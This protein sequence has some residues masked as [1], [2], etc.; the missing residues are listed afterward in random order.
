MSIVPFT[1]RAEG[2]ISNPPLR[3]L[4]LATAATSLGK[5]AFALTLGV[6][7]FREGGAAAIGLAALVQ[8]VPAAIAA[9]ILGVASDRYPRQRVLLITNVLRALML[10][11]IAVAVSAAAP[12]AVVFALAAL[13]A[14]IAT[15]SQPARAALIPVLSRT[16]REVSNAT[17]VMGSID[18]A[19]FLFGAGVGGI[20]LAATSVEFVVAL[21]AA[22]YLVASIVILGIPRDE[23]PAARSTEQPVAALAAGFKTVLR[24]DHLRLAMGMLAMLSIIDGLTNVLVIITSIELLGSGTAGIGYLNIAYGLGGMLGGSAAFALLGRSHLTVALG[25]GSIALGL[26]LILLGLLPSEA[27]GL[28]AWAAGG[29]GFVVVKI[30][31]VTLVQRLSG[32]RV[33]GRVLAVAETIFVGAIGLGAIIAPA[34]VAVLGI[35]GALIATGAALPAVAL[36]RWSALRRLEIGAPVPQREFELLRKC[37]VFAP[38]PLATTEGL[39]ARLVALEV[40]AGTDII[41]Q[42]E[43]GDRFYLIVDGAVEVFQD[44]EFR[45]RQGAG[46]SFGEIALLSSTPRTATVTAIEA[47]SLLALDR[48]PFL[49]S[50]TGHADSHDAAK[51][52]SERFLEPIEASS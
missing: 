18:I 20:L 52:V 47:T 33:L 17:A 48:D 4:E 21:C 37:P 22:A 45:R 7:A 36:L 42:G 31:G 15:A 40:D 30:S 8:A 11:L 46:E 10:S 25:M 6:F 27:L 44:G 3:R 19:S 13:F 24:D 43:L 50:V 5:A 1:A 38:L 2:V 51:D 35:E 28:L 14:T 29:F 26:P 41:T 16:P 49:I 9:P 12:I 39:A 23:R 34:L 32:D